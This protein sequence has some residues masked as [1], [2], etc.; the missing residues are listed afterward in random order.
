MVDFSSSK[1][2]EYHIVM[3]KVP[4]NNK[5]SLCLLSSSYLLDEIVKTQ[6]VSLGGNS[7][8]SDTVCFDVTEG[9]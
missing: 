9:V 5:S 7:K 2:M 1:K 6:K 4:C 3:T 8:Q